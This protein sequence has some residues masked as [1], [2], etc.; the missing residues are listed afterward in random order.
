MKSSLPLE[1]WRSKWADVWFNERQVSKV[2]NIDIGTL[3]RHRYSKPK[4][5]LPYH[6]IG[7]TNKTNGHVRYNKYEIEKYLEN[8][9]YSKT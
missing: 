6:V 4:R 1:N 8:E 9:T 3:R 7:R 2:Y 5:G